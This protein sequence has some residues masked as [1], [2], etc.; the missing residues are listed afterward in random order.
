MVVID[1]RSLVL[2]GLIFQRYLYMKRMVK[3]PTPRVEQYNEDDGSENGF[4][5]IDPESILTVRGDCKDLFDMI[6]FSPG[7]KIK[8]M[9]VYNKRIEKWKKWKRRKLG[10]R[11]FDEMGST[12][13]RAGGLVYVGFPTR[14]HDDRLINEIGFKMTSDGR[15]VSVY[16]QLPGAL[17]SSDCVWNGSSREFFHIHGIVKENVD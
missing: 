3:F 15:I 4:A 8:W 13:K 1:N 7:R 2:R 17:R 16:A 6:D 11:V 5:E 14:T 12:V 9:S 10:K